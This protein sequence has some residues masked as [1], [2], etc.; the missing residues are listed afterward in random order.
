[1]AMEHFLHVGSRTMAQNDVQTTLSETE[2]TQ[3][4]K[5]GHM[6]YVLGISLGLCAAA[7]V[8]LWSYF[9]F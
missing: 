1:M 7:G 4:I 9:A 2:A 6:R 8:A 3:G 5:I